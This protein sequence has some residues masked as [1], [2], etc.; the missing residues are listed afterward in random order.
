MNYSLI[1]DFQISKMKPKTSF[2]MKRNDEMNYSKILTKKRHQLLEWIMT[3][4]VIED[5]EIS[6]K[7]RSQLS[8]PEE[9]SE[10]SLRQS[11]KK[12]KK[13]LAPSQR[14]ISHTS[15]PPAQLCSPSSVDILDEGQARSDNVN[16]PDMFMQSRCEITATN[17]PCFQPDVRYTYYTDATETTDCNQDQFGD[18][19]ASSKDTKKFDML[20]SWNF[21]V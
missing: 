10:G 11:S 2:V 14:N 5:I 4:I 21:G 17:N 9:E 15:M 13:F 3:T 6:T 20:H 12:S 7:K 18:S 16:K 8:F 19:F 1:F